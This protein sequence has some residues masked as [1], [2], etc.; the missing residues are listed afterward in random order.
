M[1]QGGTV[2]GT[3]RNMKNRL[4]YTRK[5][6]DT[7]TQKENENNFFKEKNKI[8]S[9]IIREIKKKKSVDKKYESLKQV[10]HNVYNSMSQGDLFDIVYILKIAAYNLTRDSVGKQMLLDHADILEHHKKYS[11]ILQINIDKFS[12]I[13]KTS[14]HLPQLINENIY[15]LMKRIESFMYYPTSDKWKGVKDYLFEREDN[16]LLADYELNKNRILQQV[17]LRY[18]EL[19]NCIK[20][21]EEKGYD[22]RKTQRLHLNLIVK[23]EEYFKLCKEYGKTLQP[24][25]KVVDS[26]KSLHLL[27][28]YHGGI[29]YHLN[30]NK[31]KKANIPTSLTIYKLMYSTYGTLSIATQGYYF[32]RNKNNANHLTEAKIVINKVQNNL[33][34]S[35]NIEKSSMN[36][37]KKIK[38]ALTLPFAVSKTIV[39]PFYFVG[40]LLPDWF[41]N[42]TDKIYSLDYVNHGEMHINKLNKT[43]VNK[44]YQA[45]FLQSVYQESGFY[46]ITKNNTLNLLYYLNLDLL[47]DYNECDFKMN[48][49]EMIGYLSDHCNY[50]SII[51]FSCSVEYQNPGRH[52]VNTITSHAKNIEGISITSPINYTPNNNAKISQIF[53]GSPIPNNVTITNNPQVKVEDNPEIDLHDSDLELTNKKESHHTEGNGE[54]EQIQLN[55]NEKFKNESNY[56]QP[57]KNTLEIPYV[58]NPIRK[59]RP[60]PKG[61]KVVESRP[62]ENVPRHG[63]SNTRK[64]RPKGR[65]VDK[66]QIN[67]SMSRQGPMNTRKLRPKGRRSMINTSLKNINPNKGY[68]LHD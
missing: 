18:L 20:F 25:E 9:E 60:R 51:D 23:L 34:L 17:Q 2:L 49:E 56:V 31:L 13:F 68:S 39:R 3:L 22:Y 57:K 54:L 21:L 40:S 15:F 44:T 30:E 5:N 16:Y 33:P 10:I 59:I 66:P 1:F 19:K 63:P 55:N 36:I 48:T 6:T 52:T 37:L 32:F 62:Q 47:F 50:L 24:I 43:I 64:L 41:I 11:H 26:S 28:S 35:K 12:T 67:V 7:Q 61:R 4:F 58:A 27:I 14:Y 53:T 8:C 45:S 38:S 29:E 42:K 65:K 46:L